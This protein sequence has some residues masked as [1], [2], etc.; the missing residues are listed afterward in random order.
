MNKY[1][2]ACLS[3]CLLLCIMSAGCMHQGENV[4]KVNC[5]GQDPIIGAWQYDPASGNPALF[6]YIFKDYHQ[7]EAVAYPRDEKVPLTY[8]LVV[9]GLWV[10]AT[11]TTYNLTGQILLHDLTTGDLVQGPNNEVLTYD[12]AR[13]VLYNEQHPEALFTR[14]SCVPEVP[15]GMNV[16]VPFA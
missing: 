5:T 4:P 6:L 8:E 13:D 9:T 3:V 1:G 12:P 15:A 2:L 10:N 14:L 16:T 11:D 7:Y